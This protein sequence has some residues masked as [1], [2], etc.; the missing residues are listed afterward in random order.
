MIYG[1]LKE[2][3]FYCVVG[4][5]EFRGTVQA[6]CEWEARNIIEL[7]YNTDHVEVSYNRPL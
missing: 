7:K 2:Y 3:N 4:D 6:E 5:I 1:R